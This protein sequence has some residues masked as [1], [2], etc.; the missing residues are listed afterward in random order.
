MARHHQIYAPIALQKLTNKS[1]ETKGANNKKLYVFLPFSPKMSCQ[2][3]VLWKSQIKEMV[4]S[5][6][7]VS[8]IQ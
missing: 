3:S 6:I 2:N 1:P 5:P 4:K 7:L 8:H